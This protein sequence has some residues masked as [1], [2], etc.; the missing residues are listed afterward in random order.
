MG[1]TVQ[2]R[3]VTTTITT[4]TPR[5]LPVK[6]AANVLGVIALVAV[7]RASKK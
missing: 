1:K 7:G 5:K 6:Q 2:T 3:T 4:K